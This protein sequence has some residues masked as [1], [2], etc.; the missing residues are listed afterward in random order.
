MI[1]WGKFFFWNWKWYVNTCRV[2]L[3]LQVWELPLLYIYIY[4]FLCSFFLRQSFCLVLWHM[5]NFFYYS[6]FSDYCLHLYCHISGWYILRPSSGVSCRIWEPTLNFDPHPLFHSRGSL[7]LIPLTITW[8]KSS[9]FLYCYSLAVRIEHA[10]S[11]WLSLRSFGKFRV[12]SRVWQ[13]T[14]E[15]G[16]RTYQPKHCEYNNKDEDNSPKTLN[17]KNQTSSQKFRL[18]ISTI[19]YFML[20]PVSTCILNIWFVNKFNTQ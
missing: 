7:A 13:D 14:P 19:V 18:L 5:N 8:Y 6:G 1:Y 20:N 2:I 15:K 4:I 16:R 11:R 3:C 9:V 10:T 17:D 12:G